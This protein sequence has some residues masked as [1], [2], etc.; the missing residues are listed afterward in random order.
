MLDVRRSMFDVHLLANPSSET[1]PGQRVALCA[2]PILECAM[3][4][5]RR[6]RRPALLF[7]TLCRSVWNLFRHETV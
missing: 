5:I 3:N 2:D 1:S 7:Q 6:A 4:W